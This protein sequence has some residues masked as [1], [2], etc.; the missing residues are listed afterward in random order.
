MEENLELLQ[1]L[2]EI[3]RLSFEIQIIYSRLTLLEVS[4]DITENYEQEKKLL[5]DSLA[6]LLE[7]EKEAYKPLEN[8][9]YQTEY[10]QE[11]LRKRFNDNVPPKYR[12]IQNRIFKK[13][14]SILNRQAIDLNDHDYLEVFLE[15]EFYSDLFL[16]KDFSM[17]DIAAVVRD[18]TIPIDDSLARHYV[19]TINEDIKN[20]SNF[21]IRRH[22]I[23][24]K[25]E[26]VYEH[27]GSIEQ[28]CLSQRFNNNLKVAL[29][30]E[31]LLPG[32]DPSVKRKYFNEYLRNKLLD[33]LIVCGSCTELDMAVPEI[34][35]FKTYLLY[36][37][38]EELLNIKQRVIDYNFQDNEIKD[39]LL[40]AIND[41]KLHK[42]IHN[43]NSQNK[44][45][46]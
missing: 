3:S 38:D 5:L 24:T 27:S 16:D 11:L 32:I 23:N 14:E 43:K 12:L 46:S 40:K 30:D 26:F 35:W 42:K 17:D 44:T 13:I 36:L 41:I 39:A 22:L 19:S 21:D 33:M 10:V 2:E 25:F 1:A 29:S 6:L 8:D 15:E 4:K 34:C 31:T 18:L 37:S 28:E 9:F 20:P 7:E 45:I